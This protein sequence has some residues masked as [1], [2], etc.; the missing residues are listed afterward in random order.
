M[1]DLPMPGCAAEANG[2][3]TPGERLVER[4]AQGGEFGLATHEHRVAVGVLR[5]ATTRTDDCCASRR[6]AAGPRP[7]TAA[8]PGRGRG[9]R[10]TARPGRRGS[11][12]RA[13][14]AARASTVFFVDSTSIAEP[15][16]GGRPVSASKSITPTLYQSPAAVGASSSACSGAIYGDR[17]DHPGVLE[18][19]LVVRELRR[20]AEVEQD[21]APVG[22]HQ[23]VRRLDV[24]VKLARRM[25]GLHGLGELT[26]RG[27][28]PLDVRGR[29]AATDPWTAFGRPHRHAGT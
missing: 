1:A 12:R 29:A 4:R 10:R 26:H 17:P 14:K 22:G 25:H 5:A 16:K 11:R 27:A 7:R 6:G 21:D 23:D 8:S 15:T 20:D 19:P 2:D 13:P 9:E 28:Q 3:R 24:A 18:G